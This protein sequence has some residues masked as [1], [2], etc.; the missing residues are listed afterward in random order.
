MSFDGTYEITVQTP[1]GSQRGK[2]TIRT[3]G[4]TFSGS[5]ETASGDSKFTGGIIDGNMLD[6]QA[7]TK[8]P[9]GSFPI[10]YHATIDGENLSGEASTPLGSSPMKG[11]K[12]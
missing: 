4:N 7:E 6:W 12:I 5:L 3:S 9:L 2:L 11:I 8:T 1:M 10:T